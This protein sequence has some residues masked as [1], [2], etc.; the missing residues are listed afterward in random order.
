MRNLFYCIVGVIL[1]SCSFNKENEYVTYDLNLGIFGNLYEISVPENLANSNYKSGPGFSAWMNENDALF[2]R[3]YFKNDSVKEKMRVMVSEKKNKYASNGFYAIEESVTDSTN[4]ITFCYK[5]MQKLYSHTIIKEVELGYFVVELEGLNGCTYEDAQKIVSSIK[6]RIKKSEVAE[7]YTADINESKC[8]TYKL[9]AQKSAQIN[10]STVILDKTFGNKYF[11]LNYPSDW[12]IINEDANTID[13]I[14]I[15]IHVMQK[16][17]NDIDFLPNVNIIKSKHIESTQ[18]I[19]HI[20]LNQMKQF[21]LQVKEGVFID[22]VISGC[23]GTCLTYNCNVQG[24]ELEFYQ[25]FIKKADNTTYTITCAIDYFKRDSQKTI[26][27]AIVKSL[28]IK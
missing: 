22:I 4:S 5:E 14:K 25:Y 23:K 21:F 17:I 7:T 1:I 20:T 11:S 10:T 6:L 2:L 16:R 13:D 27:D 26:V 3:V 12:E 19:A 28:V 18:E 9:N 8:A 15:S 24:Y